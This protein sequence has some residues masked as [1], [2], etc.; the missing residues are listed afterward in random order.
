MLLLI[1]RLAEAGDGFSGGGVDEQQLALTDQR[2]IVADE[3][4]RDEVAWPAIGE[5]GLLNALARLPERTGLQQ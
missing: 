2:I 4:A 3:L 5:G 1:V